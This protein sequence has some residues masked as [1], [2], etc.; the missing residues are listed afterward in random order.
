MKSYPRRR[1][2]REINQT[3]PGKNT[4]DLDEKISGR[5]GLKFFNRTLHEKFQAPPQPLHKICEPINRTLHEKI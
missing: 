2:N 4:P 3:L 1:K 5:P